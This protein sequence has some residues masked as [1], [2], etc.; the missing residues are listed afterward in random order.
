MTLSRWLIVISLVS[1]VLTVGI[2]VWAMVSFSNKSLHPEATSHTETP[3]V[4]NDDQRGTVGHII[5]SSSSVYFIHE[6]DLPEEDIENIKWGE[7]SSFLGNP[8]NFILIGEPVEAIFDQLSTGD[9]VE[10]WYDTILES[11][12]AKIE[13]IKIRKL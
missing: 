8:T 10:I 11:Y 1:V 6:E 12:P 7:L 4:I 9:K 3:P 2:L 13:V 5:I